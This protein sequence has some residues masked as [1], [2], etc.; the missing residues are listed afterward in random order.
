ML[1]SWIIGLAFVLAA[2]VLGGLP[3]RLLRKRY[4]PQQE[5]D[6]RQLASDVMARVG[7]LHGLILALVFASANG[8]AQRLQHDITTEA[9]AATLVYFNA[10]RYGAQP[11][12]DAAV[13]YLKAVVADD[14]PALRRRYALSGTGWQAWQRLLDA[15][16]ALQP[17][18]RRDQVLAAEIQSGVWQIQHLRQARGRHADVRLP[19]EFWLVAIVGLL[20]IATLLFVH[21]IRPLHQAIMAMYSA[22]TGM[23][24][25]LIYDLS[26]PFTGA[27]NLGPDAF[28]LALR[29]IRAGL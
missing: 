22:Y 27:L 28:E 13:A 4:G 5:A 21:E 6:T 29:T 1:Q 25:F 2:I 14:W 26:H 12:Q 15:T 20:L 24:L 7:A 23:A 16:L 9:S 10:E 8:A 18:S 11:V 19:A 3:A 17:H